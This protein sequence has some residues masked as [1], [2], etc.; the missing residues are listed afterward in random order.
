MKVEQVPRFVVAVVGDSRPTTN[1][2]ADALLMSS[3]T[4]N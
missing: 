4:T 1:G 3:S 2:N